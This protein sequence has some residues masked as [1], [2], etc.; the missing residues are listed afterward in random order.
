[1][2]TPI[3]Q[4]FITLPIKNDWPALD[5]PLDIR[6]PHRLRPGIHHLP[7]GQFFMCGNAGRPV[8]ANA[9]FH[10]IITPKRKRSEPFVAGQSYNGVFTRQLT[11][12]TMRIHTVAK[13]DHAAMDFREQANG[14]LYE[15]TR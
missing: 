6:P 15:H 14:R 8:I 10:A 4:L 11:R 1:V 13:P 3:N 5:V 9:S 2:K 7:R 12:L